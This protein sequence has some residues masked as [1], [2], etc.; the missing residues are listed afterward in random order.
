MPDNG[1]TIRS[2]LHDGES[3]LVTNNVGNARRNAEWLLC[4]ALDCSVLDLYVSAKEVTGTTQTT[5]YW[6]MIERRAK[7]EP[8]QHILG[9]T[10][11]HSLQFDLRPG[12]F[13][14]RPETETL[15][16]AAELE[17]RKRP[18]Q[19]ALSVA[20][21]CCGCGTIGVSIAHLLPNA[22]ITSVDISAAAVR[23]TQENARLNGVDRRVRVFREDV[24]QFMKHRSEDL[25]KFSAVLC[26]PPYIETNMMASLPPEV[27]DHEP[28][29]ALDGGDDGLDLYRA[30]IPL[31]QM[32]M[33]DDGFV[34][35]EIGD[36]QGEA[37]ST[38]L[39]RDNFAGITVLQDYAK[40]DRVVTGF[41]RKNNG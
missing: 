12:V 1:D 2:L 35:F 23:L 33:A 37:V 10:E 31:L 21:F 5:G 4:R 39:E 38:L 22:D 8:L 17:L 16:E 24:L 13:V 6:A 18:L 27:K 3:R 11:F 34:M 29:A 20:D 7:R 32:Q 15:V 9:S 26:N 19:D 14:P 28:I 40:R 41:V 25:P 30:L 36:A